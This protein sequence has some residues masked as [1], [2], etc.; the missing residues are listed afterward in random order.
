MLAGCGRKSRIQHFFS[1]QSPQTHEARPTNLTLIMDC[2]AQHADI[3]LP[4]NMRLC[5]SGNGIDA[6]SGGFYFT[7]QVDDSLHQIESFYENEM[8][9]FGWRLAYTLRTS[10]DGRCIQVFDKPS[11]QVIIIATPDVQDSANMQLIVYVFMQ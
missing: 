2:I 4:L 11:K 5:A 9:R 7:C 8:E 10:T 6:I 1:E 3:P